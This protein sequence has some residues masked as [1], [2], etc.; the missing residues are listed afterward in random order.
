MSFTRDGFD[1]GRLKPEGCTCRWVGIDDSLIRQPDPLCPV[2]GAPAAPEG[3]AWRAIVFAAPL[4]LACW[5]LI[6][7]VAWRLL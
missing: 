6:G 2:C 5:L 1:Y 4:G 3:S 7:V